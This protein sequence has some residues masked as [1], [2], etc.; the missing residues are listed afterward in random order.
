MKTTSMIYNIGEFALH[1][2]KNNIADTFGKYLNKS[3]YKNIYR[4]LKYSALFIVLMGAPLV[5]IV[6]VAHA[7]ELPFWIS[8]TG[9]YNER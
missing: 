8:G 2:K 4:M 9:L 5:H 6:P 3:S 1:K 7:K